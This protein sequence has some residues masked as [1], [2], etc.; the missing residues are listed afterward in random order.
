MALEII[1]I[2]I[3]GLKPGT[4][5]VLVSLTTELLISMRRKA[6]CSIHKLPSATK[7]SAEEWMSMVLTSSAH[8]DFIF[9]LRMHYTISSEKTI[10]FVIVVSNSCRE[11]YDIEC[12]SEEDS[13]DDEEDPKKVQ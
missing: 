11:N 3:K 13:T 9:L 8:R 12:L 5:V 6:T 2:I 1:V 7:A 4:V 10:E